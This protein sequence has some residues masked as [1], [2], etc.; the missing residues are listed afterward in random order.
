MKTLGSAM[1]ALAMIALVDE[2]SLCPRGRRRS[3][4]RWLPRRWRR[5]GGGGFGGFG[6]GGF[7]GGGDFGGGGFDRGGFGGGGIRSRRISAVA[8]LTAA[9]SAAAILAAASIA[10]PRSARRDTKLLSVAQA[11]AWRRRL[12]RAATVFLSSEQSHARAAA[13]S[14]GYRRCRRTISRRRRP[15]IA[16]ERATSAT[17]PTPAIG[18]TRAT[19]AAAI[20][21]RTTTSI[22]TIGTT[23]IGTATGTTAGGIGRAGGAATAGAAWGTAACGRRDDALE[24]GLLPYYNPYATQ[25]Y[26][27][28]NTTVDYSQPSGQRSDPASGG[29]QLTADQP[30]QADQA[31]PT[32]STLR[33]MAFA[34]KTTKPP[35]TTS[36][37]RSANTPDDPALHEF[38]G[39]VLFATGTT[40]KPRRRS[41]PCSP[42][43]RA[44]IGR[45]SPACTRTSTCS[46]GS[47]ARWRAT[48]RHIPT[49]PT[50]RFCW[51]TSI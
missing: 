30:T 4:G 14:A 7:H 36:T 6:G 50:R 41:M 18:R 2:R 49:R 27:V 9:T 39:L 42:S 20:A 1:A 5:L 47:F 16:G 33:G 43:G 32:C 10:R 38:R 45:R 51:P 46:R 24:L 19:G 11:A 13:E 8:A 26:V 35:W 37:R 44:G 34:P 23:A 25:P 48:A 40:R 12:R 22:T 3:W 21:G 29:Q 17:V 28:D 31:S 15:E